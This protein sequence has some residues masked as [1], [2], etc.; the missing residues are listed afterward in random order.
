M[1]AG[2]SLLPPDKLTSISY[3]PFV[4][5]SFESGEYPQWYPYIF[6]G[7][8][9][10]ASLTRAPF[11]EITN[12]IIKGLISL[13]GL[14]FP[15]PAFTIVFVNYLLFGLFTYL[16]LYRK[17]KLKAI[18]VFAAL[19][20][21]FQPG[22]IA[23]AAFGH[24]TKLFTALMIPII[25]LLVEEVM[26]NRKILFAALLALAVG[27]QLLRA[28]PQMA[29]YTFM[30]I[31][32]FLL[33]WIVEG[34]IRKKNTVSMAKSVGLVLGALAIGAMMSSW[35]Y[36]SVQ[37]YAH[38]SIRGAG[39]GLDYNYA[40]NWSFSPLEVLTFFIPSFVGF[41]GQTYWGNMPFTDY[42]MYMGIVPLFLAGLA[43]VI[44]K[45]RTVW[46]LGLLA[47]L[48]LLVSFGRE[49]PIL[50]NLLF[51]YLPFSFSFFFL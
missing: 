32:L 10:F 3:E 35:M 7:M 18:A 34:F 29:Y 24:T 48:S 39:G 21:V 8:P 19:A 11:V 17:T 36:L 44:R 16:L 43:F 23:F 25:F 40:S 13:I 50:Y 14:I 37:E 4:Q 5:K 9:S 33:Y 38:Y 27:T 22:I 45:E 49:L 26:E 1:L 12:S 41:G 46:F 47:F 30:M 28:M 15:L 31:G 2:K 6:G 42:P 20:M 51:K